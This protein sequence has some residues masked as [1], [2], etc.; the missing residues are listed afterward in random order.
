MQFYC[1]VLKIMNQSPI[2]FNRTALQNQRDRHAHNLHKADFL[3][4]EVA[5]RLAE[6]L[7]DILRSFPIAADIGSHGGILGQIL[8]GRGQIET[9][10]ETDFSQELARMNPKRLSIVAD[11]ERLPLAPGKFDLILSSLSMHWVN[12][13]VGTMI[14]INH[15]LKPDGMFS[16]ALFGP[17][18]LHEL[19]TCLLDAEMEITHSATSRISPFPEV[20]DIGNVLQRAGFSLPVA[21]TEIITVDYQNPLKLLQDLRLMGES[22]TLATGRRPLRRDVLER[23]MNLYI[24]RF[25]NNNNRIAASFEIIYIHGWHP[26]KDQIQPLKPGSATHSLTDFLQTPPQKSG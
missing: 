3:F 19:R 13:L 10:I 25:S 4:R 21:D 24:E 2:L 12:D 18:T 9:L 20:R 6:R 23:A 8:N 15:A 17:R 16:S 26:H 7:N 14:Q 5:E 1:T 11:E 22:N